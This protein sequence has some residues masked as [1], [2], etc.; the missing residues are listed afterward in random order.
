MISDGRDKKELAWLAN[1]ELAGIVSLI[2]PE[3][4]T[5]PFSIEASTKVGPVLASSAALVGL[6]NMPASSASILAALERSL[7]L[8]SSETGVGHLRSPGLAAS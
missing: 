5:E 7:S 4:A 1:L 2:S 3:V 6:G 8:E